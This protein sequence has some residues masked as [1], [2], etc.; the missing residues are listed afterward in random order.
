MKDKTLTFR[1]YRFIRT[2]P[3]MLPEA[4]LKERLIED[5]LNKGYV[6]SNVTFKLVNYLPPTQV[7]PIVYDEAF[8]L[9]AWAGKRVARVIYNKHRKLLKS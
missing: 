9:S 6:P 3:G 5:Q 1:H 2:V 7:E 8:C 4:E